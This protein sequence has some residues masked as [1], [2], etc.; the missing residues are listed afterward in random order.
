MSEPNI[1]VIIVNYNCGPLLT[2]CVR[3]VLAS[4]V[5]VQVVVADNA[6]R[7]NSIGQ[8][9]NQV[10]DP[11]LTIRMNQRNLGFA[12]ANNRALIDTVGDYILFLNPDCL[13]QPDTIARMIDAM[14]AHPQA[15]VA[16]CLIH[17]EDG[18]E[19]AGCRRKVPTPL[20][21]LVRVLRLD[22]PLPFL[23]D[24]ALVMHHL[25]LPQT[26]V[27][28]ESISGAFMFV[29]RRAME[30]VGLLDEAY[31]LHCEDL[32]WFM[33]FRQQ[34]WQILF[35][36]DVPVMHVKGAC[37]RNLPVR[38]EWYKHK[39]M[40]RFYRKFFR[41]QYPLP[42]MLLVIVVVWIRFLAVSTMLLIQRSI[43]H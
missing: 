25:P 31:F 38:V 30:E 1:A 28:I 35:V 13:I 5:P 29:R 14:Q 2:D 7:D 36:P 39:G 26:P 11:R 37:S 40:I 32:D 42:L 43:Q 41:H 9:R 4:T 22:G 24:K 15:G 33:R 23:K 10:T 27:A 8:L 19:Q 12:A 18:T 20:R 16:G 3:S 6:S 34:G 21:T 17:N